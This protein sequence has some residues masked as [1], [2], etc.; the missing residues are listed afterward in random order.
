MAVSKSLRYQ[1][2]KR[3]GNKCRTC[4]RSADEV[5]LHIDHV[6]PAAL[7]GG[8][9]PSNLQALCADCNNGK[10]AVPADAQMVADVAED[11]RRWAQAMTLAAE[12][13]SAARDVRAQLHESFI[14]EWNTWSY[15]G[16]WKSSGRQ[17][18][19]YDIPGDW[20]NSIDQFI[21]AGLELRDLCDLVD[22]A[23]SSRSP[24]KWRYFCGCCWRRVRELQNATQLILTTGTVEQSDP[25]IRI[26]TRWTQKDLDFLLNLEGVEVKY[27]DGLLECEDHD[28]DLCEQ[29]TLCQISAAAR[30]REAL[31]QFAVRKHRKAHDA[32]EINDA[33]EASEYA[34]A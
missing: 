22:V 29:D 5:K 26:T 24:D 19:R 9:E 3:D 10:S 18:H 14:A 4:G 31:E 7:G 32:E 30:T 15:E 33:A 11:A 21:D 20:R 6:V 34:D 25:S 16:E 1:I 12:R 23:M 27:V 2:L 17:R 8:D 13:R 28:D